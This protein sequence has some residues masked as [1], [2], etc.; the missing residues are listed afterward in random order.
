MKL[1]T[2]HFI[3]II[4]ISA[5]L[6]YANDPASLEVRK[7]NPEHL[8]VVDGNFVVSAQIEAVTSFGTVNYIWSCQ[9]GDFTIKG[10][11]RIITVEATVSSLI[12][13]FVSGVVTCQVSCGNNNTL[14]DSCEIIW[15][16]P[17]STPHIIG[18][19]ILPCESIGQPVNYTLSCGGSS[20]DMNCDWI[21]K[22]GE[23]IKWHG[24]NNGVAQIIFPDAGA[25]KITCQTTINNFELPVAELDVIVYPTPTFVVKRYDYV[26][27]NDNKHINYVV[28]DSPIYIHWNI[29]DDD[30]SAKDKESK[31]QTADYYGCDCDQGEF[32]RDYRDD[33][34]Y[35]VLINPIDENGVDNGILKISVPTGYRLWK[36]D[37]RNSGSLLIESKGSRFKSWN[38]S[39]LSDRREIGWDK[40]S[41]TKLYIECCIPNE[42]AKK[43]SIS[44][45]DLKIG[46]FKYLSCAAGDK[47]NQPTKSERKYYMEKF[48]GLIGCE[49]FVYKRNDKFNEDNKYFN[50]I[51]FSVDPDQSIMD[52]PFW[53]STAFSTTEQLYDLP[54]NTPSNPRLCLYSESRGIIFVYTMY[55]TSM[56]QFS[57]TR[58]NRI[59]DDD[60]ESDND[61]DSFFLSGYWDLTTREFNLNSDDVKV[62]YYNIVNNGPYKFG[63]HAAR[64]YKFFDKVTRNN[65]CH[66]DWKMFV[67]KCADAGI[68]I[69]RKEQIEFTEHKVV[70]EKKEK[71]I[72]AGYGLLERAYK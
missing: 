71:N 59:F 34:L 24:N 19:K 31:E 52:G 72:K 55:I 69:H 39:D 54:A 63:F 44:Y 33:D 14:E 10:S 5:Y 8:A 4:V 48:P 47:F 38:L 61:I 36:S 32:K 51:A 23:Q 58:Y 6:A 67:S 57:H 9:G 11:G 62:V 1:K 17:Y 25:Y 18:P 16:S 12:G 3:A 13:A 21:L 40:N 68:I 49:W 60:E 2:L 70:L 28:D 41:G 37:R 56:D 64:N 30:W 65:N 53:V 43:L 46:D 42:K 20:L 50:C 26:V 7:K 45:N 29:D 22:K 15:L 27:D 66:K 35:E